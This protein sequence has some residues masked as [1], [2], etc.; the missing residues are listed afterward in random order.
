MSI[1]GFDFEAA[2]RGFIRGAT[3]DEL[4]AEFSRRQPLVAWML[5]GLDDD[6]LRAEC[7]RRGV[8]VSVVDM[9][10]AYVR[11][12]TNDQLH[13]EYVRRFG[14]QPPIE[15]YRA[16]QVECDLAVAEVEQLR[17]ERDEWKRKAEAAERVP[18]S[19]PYPDWQLITPPTTREY[20]RDAKTGLPV[21]ML[22]DAK[23]TQPE[24]RAF[25]DEDLLCE[26][27]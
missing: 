12:L 17:A 10:T 18:L 23:P 8:G 9:T 21:S 26:D 3:D 22:P 11:S 2:R 7:E 6:Q 25:L 1:V 4:R 24:P 19:V 15:K 5:A 16:L 20:A 13:A 27:A 14:G